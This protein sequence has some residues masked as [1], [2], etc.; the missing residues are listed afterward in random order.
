MLGI[1]VF[2]YLRDRQI[3]TFHFTNH[4]HL[5][6]TRRFQFL[7][8]TKASSTFMIIINQIIWIGF[9]LFTFALNM[10]NWMK[11]IDWKLKRKTD[12]FFFSKKRENKKLWIERIA[13][14]VAPKI[15]NANW[16]ASHKISNKD[17]KKSKHKQR[18]IHK[19]IHKHQ[20]L[21][22]FRMHNTPVHFI[23]KLVEMVGCVN[24]FQ[25][26]VFPY[27]FR[28]LASTISVVSSV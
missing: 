3:M 18:L 2:L 8:N 21:S 13:N 17:K 5:C 19:N 22:Q 14:D 4:I 28:F 15:M 6:K 12:E 24:G 20:E 1:F 16:M 27:I 11:K 10:F 26:K 23:I 7:G 9:A 25:F